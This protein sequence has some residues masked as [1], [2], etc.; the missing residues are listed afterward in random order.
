MQLR[1][2]NMG[3]L[4][5]FSSC[6]LL[7]QVET[8]IMDATRRFEQKLTEEQAARLKAEEAAQ[9]AQMQ[10]NYEIR[11]LREHIERVEREN[12]ELRM[13]AERGGCQIL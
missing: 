7:V 8:K 13:H 4:S 6:N 10:S 3:T 9:A 2:A 12:K 5:T 11:L 1:A